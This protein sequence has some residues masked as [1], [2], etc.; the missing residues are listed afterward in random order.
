MRL[1]FTPY[2]YIL[3]F[4]LAFNS[5]QAQNQKLEIRLNLSENQDPISKQKYNRTGLVRDSIAKE[6][7]AY[8]KKIELLGFLNSSLDSITNKDSL[9]VAY[10]YPGKQTTYLNIDYSQISQSRL[11]EKELKQ[12]SKELTDNKIRIP[13][14]EVSDFMQS[15]VDLFEEKGNSFVQFSLKDIA[16]IDN[17]ANAT[18]VMDMNWQRQIDKIVIKGYKDFPKNYLNHELNLKIGTV[19]NKEKINKASRAVNNL[20]FAK[21]VKQPE[22]LFTN[23]S[24]IIYLYLEKKKSNQFDGIIGFASKEN[25]EGLEFN[26][27]LDLKVNNLFNS[28]ETLALYWKNN[29][30]NRQRFYL[31]AELPY[32][33]NLP[34][35][36]K[37]NFEIYRQDS[38]FNNTKLQIGLLYNL[39]GKGQ[40]SAQFDSENSNDLT[41]GTT[42]GITSFSN[43]FYGISY[44]YT[45]LSYDALF[46][47][48][49][50]IDVG[51]LFGTR[52]NTDQSVAQSK[53]FLN[54]SYLYKINL[55][56][57]LFA[58]STSELLNSDN[59]FEN[60]LFR[61]GGVYNLRGVNEESIFASAY[62]VFNLE[63]RYKPNPSS[64]FYSI[65]DFSYS[66]N[67][68]TSMNTN[69]I[70]LGLGYAFQTK[71]GILNL[72]YALGKF[73]N[74][75][76]TFDNSKIHIKIISKF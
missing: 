36:P 22:I 31:A 49:L 16:L 55:K 20:S 12:L 75:P 8:Q 73:D 53:F 45:K 27:Y 69:I 61:F 2:I 46:P 64:Y 66:E 65:T 63:Y 6:I 34:L 25:D 7:S 29:G 26:G 72:S 24:T 13:F 42:P 18:L 52:K 40:I 28:G 60:E 11:T 48:T 3:F 59:Y 15:L 21:E 35:T 4:I 37:A 51:A 41:S 19:F 30:N 39:N 44:Q 47:I 14:S 71:A 76:F 38:T 10:I 70:S 43:L 32:L 58:Q 67:D 33:F 62:T 68:L 9:W 17:E 50:K 57:Y 23:D 56:N 5:L 54:A 1:K 74:E